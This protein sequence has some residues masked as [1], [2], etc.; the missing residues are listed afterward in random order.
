MTE[1]KHTPGPWWIKGPSP[2]LPT[3][4]CDDGGDYAIY[5]N[6]DDPRFNGKPRIIA[7]VINKVDWGIEAPAEAN[8][9]LIAAAPDLLA[10][11]E[12][13][14]IAIRETYNGVII[15]LR[16]LSVMN[17]NEAAIAKARSE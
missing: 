16:L 14:N 7:E 17:D 1:S 4:P 13:A 3:N 5:A 9:A 6:F 10:A 15:P 11:C 12:A 8:A 2:G